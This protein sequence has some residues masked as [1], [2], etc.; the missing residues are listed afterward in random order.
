[1]KRTVLGRCLSALLCVGLS[2]PAVSIAK[3][4][5]KKASYQKHRHVANPKSLHLPTDSFT[6]E[7]P[8][9]ELPQ[10]TKEALVATGD[11][12]VGTGFGAFKVGENSFTGDCIGFVEA[13]YHTEGIPFRDVMSIVDKDGGS[14]VRAAYRSVKKYGVL[15]RDELTP[16]PG[17]LIFW[18]NTFDFD[19]DGRFDDPL[20]HVGMVSE[21][22]PDGTIKYIHR[23]GKGVGYGYMNLS[24]PD[25][26]FNEA[27]ETINSP[28][29]YRKK[30]DPSYVKTLSGQLFVAF[31]R[32]D[33]E[34]LGP[35][36]QGK[37]NA[38][39]EALV[40][41]AEEEEIEAEEALEA[42]P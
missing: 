17:D 30:K 10:T 26:H 3:P 40:G 31:G 20:T 15:F 23:G 6:P 22:L 38:N 18:D 21:V 11:T 12:L 5:K 37:K 7:Q 27:R 28:I 34:K 19:H 36:L 1:M 29:R 42:R 32:F 41:E 39:L 14:A 16:Q 9:P 2:L 4:K 8:I 33:P 25:D 24:R 35:A 13:V